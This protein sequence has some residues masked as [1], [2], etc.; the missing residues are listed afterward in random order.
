MTTPSQLAKDF[1]AQHGFTITP[2]GRR[3]VL[4]HKGDRAGVPDLWATDV[5]GYPAA[6]NA[7]KARIEDLRVANEAIDDGACKSCDNDKCTTGAECVT[8]GLDAPDP[9]MVK[10]LTAPVAVD[11]G[12]VRLLSYDP[13]H[14]RAEPGAFAFRFNCAGDIVR[15]GVKWEDEHIVPQPGEPGYIEPH[16]VPW[17]DQRTAEQ[18]AQGD[19][20]A[21]RSLEYAAN[22]VGVNPA[23][24]KQLHVSESSLRG[25][26]NA[27]FT[28]DECGFDAAAYR[29][30][31]ID[32][33]LKPF[34]DFC[35]AAKAR[36]R[37]AAKRIAKQARKARGGAPGGAWRITYNV[38]LNEGGTTR[39]D[40]NANGFPSRGD[41]VAKLRWLLSDRKTAAYWRTVSINVEYRP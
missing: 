19:A 32:A 12:A 8:L 23:V 5:G 29:D 26:K 31:V 24:L 16:R 18:V 2:E 41:A 33:T 25:L 1:A 15:D 4:S 21:S 13:G 10:L 39:A 7:M 37:H 36:I 28:V 38:K 11:R 9:A 40:Y 27:V 35:D 17:S 6:L 14:K 20:V 22:R 3:Y 30:G 34:D